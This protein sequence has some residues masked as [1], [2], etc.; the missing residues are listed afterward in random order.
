MQLEFYFFRG[1]LLYLLEVYFWYLLVSS[2]TMVECQ[3]PSSDDDNLCSVSEDESCPALP[4]RHTFSRTCPVTPHLA[5]CVLVGKQ[6]T[7]LAHMP[8][9]F[10]GGEITCCAMVFFLWH[11]L[12]S[13]REMLATL[14]ALTTLLGTKCFDDFNQR[15]K[16]FVFP[17]EPPSSPQFFDICSNV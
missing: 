11:R 12:L 8:C 6:P 16:K 5:C 9:K 15:G 14:A 17:C 7:N 4:K 1:V 13:G 3:L 2:P 10:F